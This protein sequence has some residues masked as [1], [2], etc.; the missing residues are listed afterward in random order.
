MKLRDKIQTIVQHD[1]SDKFLIDLFCDGVSEITQRII[2]LDAN[3]AQ[4]FIQETSELYEYNDSIR[5]EEND[6][7][8]EL[9]VLGDVISV[10]REEFDS[11]NTHGSKFIKSADLIPLNDYYIAQDKTSLKFRSSTN[12][13]YVITPKSVSVSSVDGQI[14]DVKNVVKVVPIPGSVERTKVIVKQIVYNIDSSIR[15]LILGEN[16]EFLNPLDNTDG[17][18]KILFS[19]DN[20]VFYKYPDKYQHILFVYVI[21]HLI[22]TLIIKA[23][24]EEEDEELVRTLREAKLSY[25]EQYNQFFNLFSRPQ[26][27][28]GEE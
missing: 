3:K 26:E 11:N 17:V 27:A 19:I 4:H 12:P 1:Q 18:F 7:D 21:M 16:Q 8:S 5:E 28:R 2:S 22:N 23:G 20:S 13:G 14:G 24:N 25:Q 15:D 6:Y 9:I 10:L